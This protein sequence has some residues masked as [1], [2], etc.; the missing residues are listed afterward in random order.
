MKKIKITQ[1][2]AELDHL[3]RKEKRTIEGG[4]S[5]PGTCGWVYGDGNCRPY[6][7]QTPYCYKSS[8]VGYSGR[9]CC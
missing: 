4:V 7:G 1:L 3:S 8:W 5:V 9:C 2:K 6:W